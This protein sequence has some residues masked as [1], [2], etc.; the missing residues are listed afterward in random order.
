LIKQLCN[1]CKNKLAEITEV[2]QKIKGMTLQKVGICEMCERRS[3][4]DSYKVEAIN[5]DE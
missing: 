4:V 1:R 5:E 3:V 2:E